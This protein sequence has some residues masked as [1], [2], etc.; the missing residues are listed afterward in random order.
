MLPMKRSVVAGDCRWLSVNMA[1]VIEENTKCGLIYH[2][3]MT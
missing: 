2:D 3:H 1:S